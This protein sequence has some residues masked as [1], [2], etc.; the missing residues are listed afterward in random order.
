MSAGTTAGGPDPS[1]TILV[2]VH[3]RLDFLA[4]AL[5]SALAAPAPGRPP[6]VLLVGPRPPPILGETRFRSVRFV[7]SDEAGVAGKIADGLRAARG[8]LVTFL[9]DDDRYAPDRIRE[10][11]R[12]F[13]EHPSLGFLQNGYLPIGPD[14]TPAPGH[15]PHR[16]LRDRW[17]RRGPVWIIG[18]RTGRTLSALRGVP[19]G[20]NTSS[21]TIRRSLLDGSDVWLRRCGMLA[22]TALFYAALASPWDLL[23]TPEPW[24]DLRI[25][26]SS[27][28]DPVGSDGPEEM[29]RRRAFLDGLRPA[30]RVVRERVAGRPALGRALDGQEA[31]EEVIRLLRVPSA[32]R[33]EIGAAVLATLARWETFEVAHRKGAI[34]L[35]MVAVLS[36]SLAHRLYRSARRYQ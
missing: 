11:T 31:S 28:S 12:R 29:D 24:T 34:P 30:R 9:E 18:P 26:R 6:E 17:I 15:G 27:H 1:T 33:Q 2:L 25:H 13:R 32:N 7:A 8:T 5:E 21:M 36:P 22:D 35:G 23:L 3:D 20:F 19:A 10:A 4:E 14:G 16:R